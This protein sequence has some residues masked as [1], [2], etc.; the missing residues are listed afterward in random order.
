MSGNISVGLTLS[1]FA[2]EPATYDAAGFGAL[3]WVTV[4]DVESVPTFGGT[5]QIPEFIPVATG[6]VDKGKG[7]IN[8][9]ETTIPLRRRITDTGQVA[10]QSGFDGANRQ[11]VH[12]VRLAHP[13]GGTLY[14][15]ALVSGFTYNLADANAWARNEVT[16][17]LNNKPIGA[18]NVWPVTFIAGANGA[19]IGSTA[20][21]VANGT[22]ATPVYASPA[23]G[24]LFDAWSDANEDN[25]RTVTNVTAATTLTASFVLDD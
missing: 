17:A 19:I 18:A 25:P 9:G 3:A 11:T 24:Y 7:S 14:F 21:F 6:D 8:Y 12:S 16:F 15:T 20:Q 1:V 4:T 5:A 23:D 13:T 10:L 22:D 2:G